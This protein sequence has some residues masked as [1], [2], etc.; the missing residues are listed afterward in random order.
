MPLEWM[1]V[2]DLSFNNLL[3]F[4]Q[5]QIAWFPAFKLPPVEFATA[6]RANPAVDWYIR[7]KCPEIV[8]W[9]DD[10]MAQHPQDV[11]DLRKAEIAVL[12]RFVDLLV[13][14]LD[15]AVYDA[16]PFLGWDSH[17]LTGLVDFSGK[18]VIDVGA[19]TGRLAFTAREAAAVFPVEPVANLRE[20]IRQKAFALGLRNIYPVD[21]LITQIPFPEA[22]ADV[23]MGGH[24]FGDEPEKEWAELCRVTK[25]GGMVIL[26]PGNND[27]D[28]DIHRFLII[29]GCEWSRFEEPRDG[30]K[31][32]YWY[33]V[34]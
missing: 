17:E 5:A 1:D 7:H 10:L 29:Q 33:R 15:P 34:V 4:E 27:L 21:G 16:Q 19:G 8:P 12:Q 20:Y 13:Y 24:V 30:W 22:F 3:L 9:L 25:P 14:A 23:T 31:R 18:T 32:K 28:N 2:S 26:C 6:L 11:A